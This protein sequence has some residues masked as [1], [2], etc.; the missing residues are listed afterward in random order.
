MKCAAY[1]CETRSEQEE[2]VGEFCKSCR[3]SFVCG[4]TPAFLGIAKVLAE[5]SPQPDSAGFTDDMLLSHVM[6]LDAIRGELSRSPKFDADAFVNVFMAFC[7]PAVRSQVLDIIEQVKGLD[8]LM[9]FVSTDY[10]HND[11]SNVHL[12]AR[13]VLDVYTAIEDLYRDSVITLEENHLL[14]SVFASVR[15]RIRDHKQ[16]Q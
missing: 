1:K 16:L 5:A 7:S 4:T 2:F 13:K 15:R 10:G 11:G 3:D 6:T 8:R 12:H 14:E 9:N